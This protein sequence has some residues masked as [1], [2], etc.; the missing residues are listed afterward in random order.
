MRE[1]GE[2]LAALWASESVIYGR[3]GYGLGIESYSFK[4][5][6]ERTDF[7]T[8]PPARGRVRLHLLEDCRELIPPAWDAFRAQQ[9]GMVARSAAWWNVRVFTDA[10]AFREGWS[11]R[12][13][14]TY[15]RD[16]EIRGYVAYNA[17]EKWDRTGPDGEIN[18]L[19]LIA[20]DDDAYGALW[21]FIFGIDLVGTIT[22]GNRRRDEPLFWMLRD[23]RRLERNA[24]DAIWLRITD[25]AKALEN[26]RYSLDSAVTFAVRDDFLTGVG[27]TF[28]L[29]G[30]PG[31]ARCT[32]STGTAEISLDIRDLSAAYMG[33]V[34]FSTLA[35][36][37]RVEGSVDALR[38]ADLMFSWDPLP[39][40]P[41]H[42]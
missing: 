29:E 32:R 33:G 8:N 14:A 34:T 22:A 41:E 6:R 23:P 2:A 3:F 40:C 17:K 30:S 36:A 1:Q 4:I 42:F 28:R 37:G 31:G 5:R 16:G 7:A 11:E 10:E 12:H 20:L 24:E 9:P 38:R 35:R 15:E 19:E 25:I 21:R 27:G 13:I 18:V 26:R 39:W